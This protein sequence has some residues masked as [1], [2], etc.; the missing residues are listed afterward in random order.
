MSAATLRVGK[1]GREFDF[2]FDYR[3]L[4]GSLILAIAFV[5]A[6]LGIASRDAYFG[7]SREQ[8]VAV[9]VTR[10]RRH[11]QF[12]AL[13]NRLSGAR[14]VEVKALLSDLHLIALGALTSAL[15]VLGMHY[16]GLKSL[17]LQGHIQL[18]PG[19]VVI[20]VLAGS[21]SLGIGYWIIFRVIQWRGKAGESLRW[22][23]SMVLSASFCGVHH[24]G[25]CGLRDGPGLVLTLRRAGMAAAIFYG[26][27]T[28]ADQ[29][30]VLPPPADHAVIDRMTLIRWLL[31]FA[32]LYSGGCLY[33]VIYSLR[34][35]MSET[36]DD[37]AEL[38]K[39]YTQLHRYSSANSS[40]TAAYQNRLESF[41]SSCQTF[42]SRHNRNL[43]DDEYRRYS[44]LL[45]SG[46]GMT[47][48]TP[49]KIS[50]MVSRVL[51]KH[52]PPLQRAANL[53]SLRDATAATS[54]AILERVT[55][56]QQGAPQE[57]PY[58]TR[59]RTP[60]DCD[61][62]DD[63]PPDDHRSGFLHTTILD[64]ESSGHP[65]LESHQEPYRHSLPDQEYGSYA[66]WGER[67]SDSRADKS[68]P[69]EVERSGV[70]P[71]ADDTYLEDIPEDSL[72]VTQDSHLISTDVHHCPAELHERRGKEKL[73]EG[74]VSPSDITQSPLGG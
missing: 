1:D 8:R 34:M 4:F 66:S 20:S 33:A 51:N 67:A 21:F 58:F 29:I 56:G 22:I 37:I 16:I 63:K 19:I 18:K 65:G 6:G 59:G 23:S 54:P 68:S 17:L 9:L 60:T 32:V 36:K 15:G 30:R 70:S 71:K 12:K 39:K 25:G 53:G 52:W 35:E 26:D 49:R 73:E 44:R 40:T 10:I 61:A 64:R 47:S 62:H 50:G 45:S 41:L 24:I 46:R 14:S 55:V 57:S 72:E 43:Q 3:G 38:A 28:G 5:R 7:L 11:S 69:S 27:E 42:L 31:V 13:A 2:S 74:E 48:V